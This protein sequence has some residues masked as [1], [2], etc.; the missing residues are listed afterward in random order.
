[1]IGDGSISVYTGEDYSASKTR[2]FTPMHYAI[3]Q[4]DWRSS[5]ISNLVVENVD[6]KFA[7]NRKHHW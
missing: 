4:P 3:F 7:L 6:K 2:Q 5:C 1:M